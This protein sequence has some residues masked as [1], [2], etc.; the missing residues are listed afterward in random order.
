MCNITQMELPHY[1]HR[2]STSGGLIYDQVWEGYFKKYIP[3]QLLVTQVFKL[4]YHGGGVT[5]AGAEGDEAIS[6]R[7]CPKN[8]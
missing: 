1:C 4:F 2:C 8:E 6:K 5:H 7:K 3:I